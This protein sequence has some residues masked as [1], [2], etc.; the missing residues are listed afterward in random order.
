MCIRGYILFVIWI[1]IPMVA[2]MGQQSESPCWIFHEELSKIPNEELTFNS[3]IHRGM[4]NN[5]EYTGC[6]VS[7]ATNDSLY[8]EPFRA[9]SDW[10]DRNSKIYNQGWRINERYIADGPGSISFRMEKENKV[11]HIREDWSASTEEMAYLSVY[12]QC[13]ENDPPQKTATAAVIINNDVND[14]FNVHPV[15][16]LH[17]PKDTT[18]RNILTEFNLIPG[19]KV[20]RPDADELPCDYFHEQL[21][22]IPHN[23]LVWREGKITFMWDRK[24]RTGCEVTFA[25]HDS[26]LTDTHNF[27][28]VLRGLDPVLER[29]GWSYNHNYT[30][31][32]TEGR[33]FGIQ[34]NTKLCL[35]DYRFM[36][37]DDSGEIVQ[38]ADT[39]IK[40]QC[41]DEVK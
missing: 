17:L 1:F 7:F 36:I 25:T 19:E 3:G 40:V 14:N 27:S 33:I 10:P 37:S 4:D 18:I 13:R 21:R 28:Q 9:I 22:K 23:E 38:V 12:L 20:L 32:G 16:P 35:V 39:N 34:K 30:A 15:D 29:Q 24:K 41:V 5:K 11:C 2:V 31:D 26:L 6:E 8:M